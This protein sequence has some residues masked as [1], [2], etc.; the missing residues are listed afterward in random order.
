MFLIFS[1]R[2]IRGSRRRNVKWMKDQTMQTSDKRD[3]AIAWHIRLSDPATGEADWAAFNDWL[4]ADPANAEAYDLVAFDDARLSDVIG[5]DVAVANDNQVEVLPWYRRRAVFAVVA[6]ALL[7]VIGIP[8]FWSGRDF[9]TIQTRP[10]ETRDIALSDGSHITLNG[11]TRIALD[12][13][14]ERLARLE[15]GEA[16]FTIHHEAAQPFVVE[17]GG[18]TLKDVGTVFNVRHLGDALDVAVAEGAVAYNPASDDVM[19]TAGMQLTRAERRTKPVLSKVSR[20]AVAGWRQ[21][22]LTYQNA[23]LSEI[24]VDL[25]RALG[26]PVSVSPE[27]AQRR[28][29]GTIRIQ[30]DRPQFFR[31]LEALLGIRVRRNKAGWELTT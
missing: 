15:A 17:T 20:G 6:S 5:A 13:G 11:D 25:S 3:D 12:R 23:L 22:R 21:G 29:T 26:D 31:R 4:D 2:E 8:A 16:A 24:A 30:Q 18:V 27:L 19:I 28:F 14:N 9:E 1:A 7:A 10:G